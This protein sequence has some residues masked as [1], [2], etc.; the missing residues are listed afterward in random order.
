MNVKEL[1]EQSG[2]IKFY[3]ALIVLIGLSFYAGYQY[4]DK[5]NRALT[6]EI[7]VLESSVNNLTLENQALN[8]ELN[9]K[10]VELE[11]ASI[12][13]EQALVAQKE[14]LVRE[15]VLKEKVSFYQ[16]V[17]A[18]ELTQDGFM[19]DSVE[20]L[21]TQSINNFSINVMMLQRESVKSVIKGSFKI[22]LL[23]SLNGLPKSYDLTELLDNSEQKLAYSFRYFQVLEMRVTLP[24]NFI[25]E[26][27]NFKTDVYKYKKRRGSYERTVE[28]SD[29]LTIENE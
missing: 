13:N 6:A 20:I 25:P 10:K 16:K 5:Q 3:G 15:D 23:G 29:A 19:I 1:R 9:V 12:S 27:L 28:W 8:S 11:V 21:P 4:A 17:M 2:F 26:R 24:E 18:P 14:A 7:A 22:K